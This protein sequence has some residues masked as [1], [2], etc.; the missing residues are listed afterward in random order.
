MSQ[1]SPRASGQP[2]STPCADS[3]ASSSPSMTISLRPVSFATAWWKAGPS[4]ASRT[5]AV[6][7]QVSASIPIPLASAAKRRSAAMPRTT[8]SG[9]SRLVVASPCPSPA[10]TFSL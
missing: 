10:M 3:R 8:P 1:T 9:F 5:A 6:A 2:S 7:T 4:S